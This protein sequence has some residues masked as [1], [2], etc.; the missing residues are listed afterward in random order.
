MKFCSHCGNQLMDDAV[1]CPKCGCSVAGNQMT[2]EQ[3]KKAKNQAKGVI[4]II[5]GVAVIIGFIVLVLLQL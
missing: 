1:M 2:A 3:K 5:V 4:L